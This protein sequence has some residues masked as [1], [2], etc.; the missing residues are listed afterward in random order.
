MI[1]NEWFRE[2][3]GFGILALEILVFVL[4]VMAIGQ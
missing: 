4:M 3:V 1:R 2:I